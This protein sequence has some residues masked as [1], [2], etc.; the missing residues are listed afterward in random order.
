MKNYSEY[1]ALQRSIIERLAEIEQEDA[2]VCEHCSGEDCVCCEI[3][4]DRQRW[5]SIDELFAEDDNPC[6]Q[7]LPNRRVI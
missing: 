2:E 1:T 6:I 7:G 3:Y 4:I 5:V